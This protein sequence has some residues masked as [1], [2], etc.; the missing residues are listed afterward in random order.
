MAC[1]TSMECRK[2]ARQAASTIP[3][4]FQRIFL[5]ARKR[6]PARKPKSIRVPTL[7]RR[8]DTGEPLR[9]GENI[10]SAWAVAVTDAFHRLV[11]PN[12]QPRNRPS[13]GPNSIAPTRTGR[14][15]NVRETG[16]TMM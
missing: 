12:T 1:S 8:L 6:Q 5:T 2:S 14:V 10:R 13:A 15:M 9:N 7:S 4:F 16:G 11:S 3:V